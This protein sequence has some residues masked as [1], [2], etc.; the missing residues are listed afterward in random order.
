MKCSPGSCTAAALTFILFNLPILRFAGSISW[1]V[2]GV[3]PSKIC[4]ILLTVKTAIIYFQVITTS[5]LNGMMKQKTVLLLTVTGE[6]V[7]LLLMYFLSA[8]RSMHIY[9]YL[10]AMC[11]G[12]GIRLILSL[13]FLAGLIR[14]KK[15]RRKQVLRSYAAHH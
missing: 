2:F 13:I 9:G 6:A 11:I 3:E 12:E 4:F 10:I 7:Q 15:D 14:H 5:V 1:A 8:D